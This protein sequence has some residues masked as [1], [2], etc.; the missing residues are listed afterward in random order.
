MEALITVPQVTI[1]RHYLVLLKI[2]GTEYIF[3]TSKVSLIYRNIEVL[4]VDHS[5][6]KY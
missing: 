4:A 1:I 2:R 3:T 6:T 5:L